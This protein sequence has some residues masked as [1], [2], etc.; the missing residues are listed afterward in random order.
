M[1]SSDGKNLFWVLLL[2]F[3][4]QSPSLAL[5][6]A[7]V[8]RYFEEKQVV[9]RTQSSIVFVG[10][11]RSKNLVYQGV[12]TTVAGRQNTVFLL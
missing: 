8:D 12:L 1:H 11:T 9:L 5:K 2:N 6:S 4:V 7:D 10:M 3:L